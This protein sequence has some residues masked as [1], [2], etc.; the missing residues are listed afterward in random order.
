MNI[1]VADD[2]PSIVE[3]LLDHLRD[4]GY[5]VTGVYDGQALMDE[6]IKNTPDLIISDIDM[7]GMSGEVAQS[8]I[9][10]YPPLQ[11]IPFI[12][13][14]GTTKARIPAL[15]LSQNTVILTKP[16]DF[17]DLDAIVSDIAS[18]IKKL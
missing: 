4:L 14:T 15:G 13:I 12:V 18:K 7:P 11:K 1:L 5:N 10:L 16:V 2:D 9:E 6:A 3:L 17:N 8:M